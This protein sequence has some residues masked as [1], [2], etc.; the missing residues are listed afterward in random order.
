MPYVT[1]EMLAKSKAREL[2]N[3]EAWRDEV[4]RRKARRIEGDARAAVA[5][6]IVREHPKRPGRPH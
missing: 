5:P 6:V 2:Q 4:K 3:L 1:A